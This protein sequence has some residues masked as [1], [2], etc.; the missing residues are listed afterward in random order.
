MSIARR[1]VRL[2]RHRVQAL[3][4]SQSELASAFREAADLVLP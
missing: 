3:E 2:L 1:T 4:P